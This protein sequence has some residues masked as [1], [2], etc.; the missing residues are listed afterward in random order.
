MRSKLLWNA[1]DAMFQQTAFNFLQRTRVVKPARERGYHHMSRNGI[2]FDYDN[3]KIIH[4]G[5]L[6]MTGDEGKMD[7]S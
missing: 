5:N 2:R 6:K 4:H 3:R 1:I 7:L